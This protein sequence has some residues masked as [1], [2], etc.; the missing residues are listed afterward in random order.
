MI[1]QQPR[2]TDYAKHRTKDG[3]FVNTSN[4]A[5]TTTKNKNTSNKNT[6]NDTSKN[7]TA[8]KRQQPHHQ[9]HQ[10]QHHHQKHHKKHHKKHQQ[11]H[12]KKHQQIYNVLHGT[13]RY[14]KVLQGTATYYHVLRRTT[15]YTTDSNV[16]RSTQPYHCG[17]RFQHTREEANPNGTS[18][19]ERRHTCPETTHRAALTVRRAFETGVLGQTFPAVPHQQAQ[20]HVLKQHFAQP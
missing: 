19:P 16:R 11:H 17:K 6:S 1:S 8:K 4:T 15:T 20:K 3:T 13:T 9:K 5:T 10:Q 12:H 2:F 14:Y 7:T 18:A